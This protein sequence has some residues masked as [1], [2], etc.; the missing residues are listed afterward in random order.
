MAKA[1][2]LFLLGLVVISSLV[3]LTE[4]R[5]LSL[6]YPLGRFHIAWPQPPPSAVAIHHQILN[7]RRKF[8]F[9]TQYLL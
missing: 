1:E 5:P 8:T 2:G 9:N 3:M 7:P 6:T 4:S